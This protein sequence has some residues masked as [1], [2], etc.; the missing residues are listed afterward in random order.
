[1]INTLHLDE[2][3]LKDELEREVSLKSRLAAVKQR[4]NLVKLRQKEVKHA[5]RK[6]NKSM[7]SDAIESSGDLKPGVKRP[8]SDISNDSCQTPL[9][10]S[11]EEPKPIDSQNSKELAREAKKITR[12]VDKLDEDLSEI[13]AYITKTCIQERN[14]Y[15]RKRLIEDFE[16]GFRELEE[17]LKEDDEED[18]PTS[19]SASGPLKTFCIS[20]FAFQKLC[21]NFA[22]DDVSVP[23]RG[24]TIG[25]PVSQEDQP[26]ANMLD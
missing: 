13:K 23:S 10:S 20:S 25:W 24:S 8:H 17:E 4:L 12:I 6:P 2:S 1:M 11:P 16:G 5:L 22:R 14:T 26:E 21:G 7:S 9:T 18:V 3:T 15:T 19:N